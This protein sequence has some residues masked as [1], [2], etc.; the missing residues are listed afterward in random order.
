MGLFSFLSKKK[1]QGEESSASTGMGVPMPSSQETPDIYADLPAFSEKTT[2]DE[3]LP[4]LKPI[5]R[6]TS[7]PGIGNPK[8]ESN[9]EIS[10]PIPEMPENQPPIPEDE[11]LPV[12]P[13]FSY[14]QEE[15]SPSQPYMVPGIPTLPE[16]SEEPYAP[17]MQ[18]PEEETPQIPEPPAI[19]PEHEMFPELPE[20]KADRPATTGPFIKAYEL[21]QIIK[22]SNDLQSSIR[23]VQDIAVI[24]EI[25]KIDATAYERFHKSVENLQRKLMLAEKMFMKV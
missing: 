5:L 23:F 3:L 16:Q 6:D 8:P 9:S 13:Q 24:N 11:D 7:M 20:P 21:R 15:V 19:E 17:D 25:L 2:G 12:P 22:D 1:N 10:H 14:E 18:T 4:P